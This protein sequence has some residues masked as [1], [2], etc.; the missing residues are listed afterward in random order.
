MKDL[1]KDFDKP[2]AKTPLVNQNRK[3]NFSKLM[4]IT[5]KANKRANLIS[6]YDI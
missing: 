5:E 4:K 2:T 3:Y 1:I 6:N